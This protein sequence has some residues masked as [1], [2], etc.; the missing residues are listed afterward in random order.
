MTKN[1][2]NDSFDIFPLSQEAVFVESEEILTHKE[3]I[4]KALEKVLK[5]RDL[6]LPLGPQLDLYNPDRTIILN[7]FEVQIVSSGILSDEV[8][9]RKDFW[10]SKIRSPQI[11]L[12]ALIDDDTNI[13]YFKGMLTGSEL[14]NLVKNENSNQDTFVVKTKKF[15]GGIDRLL[16][17]VRILNTEAVERVEIN[18]GKLLDFKVINNNFK[19]TITVGAALAGTILFGPELLK[20][21]LMGGIALL[22]TNQISTFSNSTTRGINKSIKSSICLLSPSEINKDAIIPSAEISIDKPLLFS[23]NELKEISILKNGQ[24]VWNS[25]LKTTN[26]ISKPLNWPIAP[27]RPTDNYVVALTP[28]EDTSKEPTY[29]ELKQKIKPLFEIDSLEE[30]LGKNKK[31]WEKEISKNL[32]DNQD[33]ALSLLYSENIPDSKRINEAR[34]K[35]RESIKCP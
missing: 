10:K 4:V 11:I 14:K 6:D 31:L 18:K 7:K 34:E 17:S 12:A 35:I 32:K 33:L 1:K 13:V 24:E 9:I 23:L 2:S 21:R 28:G 25:N 19:R 20:P 29:L 26:L 3:L 5:D 8:K 15:K 27:I 30:R 16:R 22:E